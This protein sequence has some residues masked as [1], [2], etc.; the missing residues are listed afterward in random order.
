MGK[1]RNAADL[2]LDL[3]ALGKA[4]NDQD[5]AQGGDRELQRRKER[6][7][8]C[9][10]ECSRIL[11]YLFVGG[12][13]VAQNL[14]TLRACRI[15][16]ILNCVGFVC[17]EYFPNDFHYMTLWLQDSPNEDIFCILYDVFDYIETVREKSGS[18]VLVHCSQGVSRSAALAIAYL[19][20]RKHQGFEDAYEKV[21]RK[22]SVV[23]PNMGF[24]GQLMQWQRKILNSPD[25]QAFQFYR[26]APHS[27]FDP[28][29]LVPKNVS[30]SRMQALDSRGAFVIYLANKLYV[31]RGR[32]CDKE[33]AAVADRAAF[34][35]VRYEHAQGPIT[36]VS[37]GSEP[38]QMVKAFEELNDQGNCEGAVQPVEADEGISEKGF[39]AYDS[40]FEMY[41]KAKAGGYVP[42]VIG[43]GVIIRLP[44]KE[45]WSQLKAY[46]F[47]SP[48]RLS[49]T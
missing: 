38:S 36:L 20:W 4:T 28:L 17:P 37:D 10:K 27:A 9:D 41:K 32:H 2:K 49:E 23:S 16:H 46:F 45:R 13:T 5:D 18:R 42:P 47:N 22:R 43:S 40:D 25:R 11:P 30:S 14:A 8:E 34:Q 19:M 29:Y 7:A 31:W 6:M 24:V 21:K 35:L 12:K 33:M 44:A 26:I 3:D 48:R 39:S 1:A 15:T